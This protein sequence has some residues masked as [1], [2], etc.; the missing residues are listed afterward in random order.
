VFRVT[1][2]LEGGTTQGFDY[3]QD[4]SMQVGTRVR[5]DNGALVRL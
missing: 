2:R 1:V 3:A 4:P 5:V